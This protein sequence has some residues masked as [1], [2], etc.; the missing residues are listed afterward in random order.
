MP[1][2]LSSAVSAQLVAQQKRPTLL[3]EIGLITSA[4]TLYYA[5]TKSDVTWNGHTYTAKAVTVG[6]FSQSAEGQIGSLKVNFDNVSR[7]MAGYNNQESFEGRRLITRRVFVD[8]LSGSTDYVG[9]FAGTMDTVDSIGR[10][11][12]TVTATQ[13][14]PLGK[15]ALT[16]KYPRYCRHKFGG[17]QCDNDGN[18]DLSTLTATGTVASVESG[19]V[20]NFIDT[21][22]PAAAGS[23]DYYNFGRAELGQ[24]GTTYHVIVTDFDSG[25]SKVEWR[26]QLPENINGW[27]YIIYKGCD[28]TWDACGDNENWGPS[29]DNEDNF[30][31]F[32]HIGRDEDYTANLIV[33]EVG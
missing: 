7:D 3:F 10:H 12:L 14:K 8:A 29:A 18:A 13:G 19:G 26:V 27:N 20:T 23:D 28:K 4:T 32:L 22:L 33:G 16:G 1:K 24:S 17:T 11:W 15:K 9:L 5:A 25:T 21:G 30:G 31:G 6:G 2:T